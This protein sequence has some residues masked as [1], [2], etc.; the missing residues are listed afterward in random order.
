M[1]SYF[2]LSLSVAK[3]TKEILVILTGILQFLPGGNSSNSVCRGSDP[4][5]ALTSHLLLY[6][7]N[8]SLTVKVSPKALWMCRS[9]ERDTVHIN[10]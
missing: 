4:R 10:V 7:A 5:S 8:I 2:I 6:Y 9:V 1:M 3:E